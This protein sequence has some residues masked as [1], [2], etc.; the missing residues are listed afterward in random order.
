MLKLCMI[1]PVPPP[2]GGV[3]NWVEIIK[4][5]IS[6]QNDIE[7]D[8]ISTS[9]NKRLTD[10]RTTSNRVFYGI[11]NMLYSYISLNM[12]IRSFAPDVVHITTS[13]GLGFF[14]DLLLLNFLKK[15][16]I[17]TVYHIHFGRTV[18][19]EKENRRCWRQIREAVRLA[20]CT[21]VLD[22]K[23]YQL[24]KPYCNRIEKINN[25]IPLDGYPSQFQKSDNKIITYMGSILKE[26]G[27]EELLEG[28]AAFRMNA[29][30]YKLRM[31]GPGRPEYLDYLQKH[32]DCEKVRFYGEV[33]HNEAIKLL[34]ETSIF[35]LPSYTE[36]FPNV[37]LEA[38]ALGKCIISTDV[39]AIPEI[40][41]D[42]AGIII[43]PKDAGIITSALKK[44]SDDEEM[45][46]NTSKIGFFK[47]RKQYGISESFKEYY[48]VWSE[49][50]TKQF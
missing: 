1:A 33:S 18:L 10:G 23:T 6:R 48:K 50:T 30:E 14:R 31:I 17:K 36:G 19:Y 16:N 45:R 9:V 21:I 42:G 28:F 12:S 46:I 7:L 39:G 35:I 8:L 25:P 24:L 15:R 29:P 4:K 27:V 3:A 32:Y 5:E 13:G 37:I 22:A 26:K 20:D 34:S 38:M 2:Y 40:L 41:S 44:V 49:L 43:Q 47:V 11:K